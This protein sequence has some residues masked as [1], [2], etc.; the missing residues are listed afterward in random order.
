MARPRT[1]RGGLAGDNAASVDDRVKTEIRQL[2][3]IRDVF[4]HVVEEPQSR[5]QDIARSLAGEDDPLF[6]D[7][8]ELLAVYAHDAIPW[9]NPRLLADDSCDVDL[10]ARVSQLVGR[11]RLMR[12]LGR[13]GMG[14]VY[15]A[16]DTRLNRPVAIKTVLRSHLMDETTAADVSHDVPVH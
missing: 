15:E 12:L 14:A 9:E 5:W 4:D 1:E 7:V 8:M 11:Y 6:N 2:R 13:G 3:R 16:L 10:E